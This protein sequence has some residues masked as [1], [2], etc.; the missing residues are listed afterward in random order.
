MK[1]S[2]IFISIVVLLTSV[3]AQLELTASYD[4]KYDD[5]SESL[6]SVAC[7]D[8]PNGLIT[9]GFTTFGSLPGFPSIGG[10]PAVTGFDSP[11]CG[12]C[13]ELTYVNAQGASR[14]MNILVIDVAS[15]NYNIVLEALNELTVT[16]GEFLGR[17]PVTAV[18]VPSSGCGLYVL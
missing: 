7:S 2:L 15:P 18:E 13:W 10:G 6:T 17:V 3:H 14:S 4:Q 16:E 9:R 11:G 1:L 5:A 12:T 8:G